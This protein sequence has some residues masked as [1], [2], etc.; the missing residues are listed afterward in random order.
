[1]KVNRIVGQ[2]DGTSMADILQYRQ[3]FYEKWY[4]TRVICERNESPESIAGKVLSQVQ[5][6]QAKHGYV[7]TRGLHMGDKGFNDVL[8]QGLSPDGGL[9]VP[10]DETPKMSIGQLSR[11]VDLTYPERAVRILEQWIDF[12]DL[13]SRTLKTA[14]NNA[15]NLETFQDA[16]ICPVR[17]L[18]RGQYIQELFHGPTASFKDVALQLMP[19]LFMNAVAEESKSKYVK[20]Q[21]DKLVFNFQAQLF[22]R[23]IRKINT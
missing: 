7:S 9:I 4:D 20:F 2:N 10:R 18:D 15:Y 23:S 11:L 5:N 19:Q 22:Q 17:H 13:H 8:L 21:P 3:Q 16:S 1:M 12:R 14:V 6:I